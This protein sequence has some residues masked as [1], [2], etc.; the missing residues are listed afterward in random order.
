MDSRLLALVGLPFL[1]LYVLERRAHAAHLDR[2]AH[3]LRRLTEGRLDLPVT[4]LERLDREG[5]VAR[6]M[7]SLSDIVDARQTEAAVRARTAELGDNLHEADTPDKFSAV[8]FDHVSRSIPL[9][10]GALYLAG[11]DGYGLAGGLGHEAVDA[12][13]S[14]EPGSGLIGRAG[15]E[16]K[17]IVAAS[18]PDLPLKL[19]FGIGTADPGTV[20]VLPA[21]AR[22]VTTAVLVIAP[23]APVTEPQMHLLDAILSSIGV[24][25]LILASH[26]K[27]VRL[28]DESRQQTRLLERQADELVMRQDALRAAEEWYHD[29]IESAPDGILICG[30]GGKIILAN[31][32]AE[33]MFGYE[34]GAL[35]NRTIEDL[36]PSASRVGHADLRRR[37]VEAGEARSIGRANCPLHGLRRDGSTFPADIGLSPLPVSSHGEGCVCASVRDVSDRLQAEASVRKSRDLLQTII[38]N[39]PVMIY[40]KDRDGRYVFANKAWSQIIGVDEDELVGKLASDILPSDIARRLAEADFEVLDTGKAIKSEE[41]FVVDGEAR[42]F[43]VVKSP[44]FDAQGQVYGLCGINTDITERKQSE[45]LLLAAKELAESA[46]RAKSDFLANMSHEIRTPLNAIIGM[47]HLA[48]RAGTAARERDYLDKI[49][50]AGQHLLEIVN[51]VLD[52]SK[53]ESG[54]MSIEEAEIHLE[55]LLTATVEMVVEKSAEKGLE[56]FL[57]LAPDIPNDLVGDSLRLK[58]ILI[59][60]LTNAVKFTESGEIGLIVRMIE[61]DDNEVTLRFDV[62]DTGIGIEQDKIP[63]LFK[64]FEQGDNSVTRQYGGTGLGLAISRRLAEMMGGEC[65]VASV[66]GVGSTFWFTARLGKRK[67][68]RVWTPHPDLRRLRVLI[69]DDNANVRLVMEKMLGAMGLRVTSVATFQGAVEAV[70]GA[71]AADA[72]ALVLLDWEMPGNGV[73]TVRALR[74]ADPAASL[75]VIALV[76]HSYEADLQQACAAVADSVLVKPLSAS[77]V[78]DG[79]EQVFVT[80][81]AGSA[82]LAGAKDA[83]G[84]VPALVGLKVLLVEDNRFNQQVAVELLESMGVAATI[85]GDG[86]EAVELVRREEFDLLLM[87]VQMPVMDGIT[88]TRMIRDAGM[89]SL[90]I[91]AMTANAMSEDREQCLGAG[92]NDYVAKPIDPEALAAALVRWAGSRERRAAES[93]LTGIAGFDPAD[94]LKRARGNRQLFLKLLRQFAFGHDD[95]AAR[96]QAALAEGDR[97]TAQRLSHSLKAAAGHV[98]AKELS[99]CAAALEAVLKAGGDGEAELSRLAEVS[100]SLIGSLKSALGPE[101]TVGAVSR[102]SDRVIAKLTQL[103]EECDPAAVDEAEASRAQLAVV[104]GDSS[105]EFFRLLSHYRFDEALR[106]LRAGEGRSGDGGT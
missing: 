104:L 64:G 72:F 34:R 8:V 53:I 86:R 81:P 78:F 74:E 15:A 32:R 92:M 97:P 5:H 100:A 40:V 89:E 12:V 76:P 20:L 88:A 24:N 51:D 13:F 3:Y 66:P 73:D 70:R 63:R 22:G 68:K 96:M 84:L 69:A 48:Q 103:M 36:V 33:A 43:I 95:V 91:I 85:A 2:V 39:V 9:L 30:P 62:K 29:I 38:D 94:G 57:D 21:V 106:V 52:F 93:S 98:G 23:I 61:E 83:D 28:L 99:A 45:Q 54:K 14:V 102:P 25:A 1:L 26:L 90:P 35:S 11:D 105:K 87:D 18:G 47:T 55:S 17:R 42:D 46:A 77:A 82:E 6:A 71:E 65:G 80:A 49:G 37:F 58:Q 4:A 27:T 56:L 59:N 75:R 19:S 60:Y 101:D 31:A 41:C 44:L 7:Q 10:C 79:I 50:Q 67:A 16:R